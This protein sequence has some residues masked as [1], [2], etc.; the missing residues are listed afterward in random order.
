MRYTVYVDDNF[1]YGDE[2]ERYKLGRF[3]TAERAIAAA[4]KV[5]DEYLASAYQPG[6]TAEEL[7]RSYLLFGD[8]PYIVPREPGTEFSARDY[9][10][11]RCDE[12]CRPR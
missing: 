11:A 5:V 9:A 1:H 6:M 2:S 12:L 7:D 3:R 4:K 8:D 10:R